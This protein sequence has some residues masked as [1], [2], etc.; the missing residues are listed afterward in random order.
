MEA[1]NQKARKSPVRRTRKQIV[2]LLKEYESTEGMTIVDFCKLHT[3]NK[4]NFYNWQKRY[5]SK[6]PGS[7][8]SKGFVPLQITPLSQP[9]ASVPLLFAEVKGIR[10]YQM[11][12]AEYLKM[13]A[14]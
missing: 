14:Q 5:G 13:L 2:K 3:I 11:V 4:S 10:I 12:T 7:N 9:P 8:K 6:R 1:S